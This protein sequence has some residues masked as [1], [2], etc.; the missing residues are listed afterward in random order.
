M[1]K[2]ECVRR[3]FCTALA[4]CCCPCRGSGSAIV[5]CV[6][7]AREALLAEPGT[8]EIVLGKRLVSAHSSCPAGLNIRVCC[9]YLTY[10]P[11]VRLAAD[12]AAGWAPA[13]G[14]VRVAVQTGASLVPVL[15]FGENDL[16]TTY[17]PDKASRLAKVQRCALVQTLYTNPVLGPAGLCAAPA[18]QASRF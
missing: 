2:N 7:G 12:T 3:L 10:F 8:F 14:F 18:P 11:G 5:L 16:F 6:G 9:M 4:H 15:S 13:Q 17:R 1:W